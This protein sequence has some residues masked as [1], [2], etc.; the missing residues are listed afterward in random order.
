MVSKIA[1]A[2]QGGGSHAA[3]AAGVLLRL[4]S[5]ELRAGYEL[6][7]ISGTS[8]GA[9]CAAL[10]W[11]GLICEGGGPD[12]AMRRLSGFWETLKADD[13]PSYLT[14]ALSLAA[15]RLPVTMEISPYFVPAPAASI[16]RGWLEDHLRL[17][18][19]KGRPAAPPQLLIG[20][21]D[22]LSGQRV[23]IGGDKIT[24]DAL[25]ASAAVPF[26]YE[27][28]PFE[29]FMLWDGLFSVNPPVRELIR[30]EID[31]LWIIQINPQASLSVP[32]TTAEI[33]DRRNE[34]SGNI[35]LAQ[36]LH[37]VHT[38]N[39]LLA[40]QAKLGDG[41]LPLGDGNYRKV[42]IRLVEAGLDKYDYASKLDRDPSFIDH[43]MKL[44]W[45]RASGF[46]DDASLWPRPE[47]I[48]A[49]ELRV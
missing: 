12:E 4:L 42:T 25:I 44:G 29:N 23:V 41:T 9:M 46:F 34:L 33:I 7:G 35:A 40:A 13:L 15:A 5:P 30:E 11:A 10:A 17:D 20:A 6:K 18:E 26:L 16:M 19:I 32:V 38:I 21:T 45:D 8:G 39:E 43:L 37:F 48:T 28:V 22:V 27:A 47:A 49:K 14:N 3:F 2:C 36:E 24:Y 31:E 1:I